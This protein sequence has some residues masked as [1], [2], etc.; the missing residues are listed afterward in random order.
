M[1][2]STSKGQL[3]DGLDFQYPL[4]LLSLKCSQLTRM[5]CPFLTNL[6]CFRNKCLSWWS[7]PLC[8]INYSWKITTLLAALPLCRGSEALTHL[9]KVGIN[10]VL[11]LYSEV[12]HPQQSEHHGAV[13]GAFLAVTNTT[14]AAGGAKKEGMIQLL[15]ICPTER[16]NLDSSSLASSR[17]WFSSHEQ[18]SNQ[19]REDEKKKGR[20]RGSRVWV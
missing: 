2:T 4:N 3:K 16:N 15:I 17:F 18:K 8:L 9:A 11:K 13:L 5:T 1:R 14:R 6:L 19:N 7:L 20:Q 10:R 12:T